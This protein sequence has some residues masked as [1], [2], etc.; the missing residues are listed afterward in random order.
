LSMTETD[1][2]LGRHRPRWNRLPMAGLDKSPGVVVLE[3][4]GHV[5]QPDDGPGMHI[6][7]ETRTLGKDLDPREWRSSA[8]SLSVIHVK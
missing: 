7:A 6:Q 5:R 3:D 4:A 8:L 2:E 1:L